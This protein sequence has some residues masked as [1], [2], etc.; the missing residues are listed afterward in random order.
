M[1]T[2]TSREEAGN[3]TGLSALIGRASDVHVVQEFYG[4]FYASS[5]PDQNQINGH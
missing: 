1:E 2:K 5:L 3:G 4:D